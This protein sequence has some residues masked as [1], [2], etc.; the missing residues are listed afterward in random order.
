MR[1]RMILLRSQTKRQEHRQIGHSE[2]IDIDIGNKQPK[3]TTLAH[4]NLVIT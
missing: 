2:R 1:Q 4:I 3:L